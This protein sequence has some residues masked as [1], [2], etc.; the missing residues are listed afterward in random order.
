MAP[1]DWSQSLLRWYPAP[2]RQR[3]G[4]ELV[5]MI[6][7]VI[8]EKRP[9][10]RFRWSIA[11]AGLRERGHASGLVGF[12]RDARSQVQAGA[13]LVL[14]SWSAFVIAGAMFQKQSEHYARVVPV[15][16]R[17]MVT[18]VYDLVVWMSGLA[19]LAVVVG[20]LAALPAFV[21]FLRN[22]GWR[23]VRRH[24][25]AAT[26]LSLA[27][28]ATLLVLKAW[29]H[30]LSVVQRNGENL[31]YSLAFVALGLLVCGVII[32]WT[33]VGVLS[34]RRMTLSRGVLR[35]EARL[36]YLVAFS[37]VVITGAVALWWALEGTVAPSFFQN[38][39]KGGATIAIT[40][41]LIVICV[42][43]I[44]ASLS[45]LFGSARILHGWRR[46]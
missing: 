21:S 39:T 3:Y 30:G 41:N 22:D 27:A 19:S 5:V 36:A 37:M 44:A 38:G 35:F 1:T 16:S 23:H 11:R 42:L 8:G 12:Q 31:N 40:P 25:V 24:L 14:C 18:S 28:L 6:E 4:N 45:G 13:L 29:A 2:W 20:T 9:S 10:I 46:T 15:A 34:V 7:D 32:E 33:A 43:M 17:A 26:L